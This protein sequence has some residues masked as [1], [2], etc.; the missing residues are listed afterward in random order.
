MMYNTHQNNK[1]IIKL[2]GK[3]FIVRNHSDIKLTLKNN[4]YEWNTLQLD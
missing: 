3:G 4:S 1:G 2:K